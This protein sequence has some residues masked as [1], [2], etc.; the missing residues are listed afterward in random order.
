MSEKENFNGP[1]NQFF[2]SQND[3][4]NKNT[5][6]EESKFGFGGGNKATVNSKRNQYHKKPNSKIGE[7]VEIE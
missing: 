5:L 7:D 2:F 3:F 6:T 4:F 1:S